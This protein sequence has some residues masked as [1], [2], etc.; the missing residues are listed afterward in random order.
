MG[1]IQIRK[2]VREN[3]RLV[4]ALSSTTGE[5]KTLTA[6]L[7][8]YGLA[9]FRADKLGFLDAEN[10][11]GSLYADVLQDSKFT[12]HP[13]NEQFLIADLYAPFSPGRYKQAIMEF[14]AAGVE[15]LIIDSVTHEWEGT[16]GCQ[17][18]AEAGNPKIP[19][20]NLAKKLHKD[21]MNTLL[22][23]DMHVIVCVRAREKSKPE[24]VDGKLQFVELGL[25]PI[26]EKNFMFEMT[27]SLMMHKQGSEQAILKC[28]AALLNI[29]G[30]QKG[31]I[32]A[33]DGQAIRKWVDGA[34]KLDPTIERYRNRL[35]SNTEG[36]TKH[37]QECWNMTPA[38]VQEALG[39]AFYETLIQAA[40][41][42]EEQTALGEQNVAQLGAQEGG[43]AVAGVPSGQGPTTAEQSEA[44]A[45]AARARANG[46]AAPV[47]NAQQQTP[48]QQVTASTHTHPRPD[49]MA[50][51]AVDQSSTAQNEAAKRQETPTTM[52]G[53]LSTPDDMA[54]TA[55][56]PVKRANA[57]PPKQKEL[58]PPVA[59]V[60]PSDPIF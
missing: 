13:T 2:A 10:R 43:G 36:G 19:N 15:V 11:R 57:A 6:I 3:A 17:E 58:A 9:N 32:T 22:Q 30:R 56:E 37:I 23:S 50:T 38:G 27:A 20:W 21:F 53:S 25:Q 12:S 16:G 14:Q 60:L 8:G 4:F 40:K 46:A 55:A 29:L 49:D 34:L 26:Q 44:D 54:T 5:G 39:K 47:T 41:G 48:A 45:I 18:I 31:Y 52:R 59:G 35:I 42:Y 51:K 28:P 24:R 33:D 7:L 1:V